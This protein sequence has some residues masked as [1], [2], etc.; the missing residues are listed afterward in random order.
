VRA[1]GTPP[2]RRDS[3]GVH[4]D[5]NEK[6]YPQPGRSADHIRIEKDQG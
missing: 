2:T 3:Q 6:D 1:R 5:R 4:A